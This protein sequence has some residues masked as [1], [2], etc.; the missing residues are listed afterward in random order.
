MGILEHSALISTFNKLIS[1]IKTFVLSIFE[2]P[3]YT[4]FSEHVLHSS[5]IFIQLTCRIPYIYKAK[6][7]MENSVDLDQLAS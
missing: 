6:S 1:V 5:P 4:G 7:K 2:W 3:F